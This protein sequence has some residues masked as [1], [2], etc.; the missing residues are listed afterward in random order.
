MRILVSA[1]PYDKGK[2]GISVYVREVV[3]ELVAQ[4]HE[5][6]LLIEPEARGDW[7]PRSG[8]KRVGRGEPA[9]GRSP[10]RHTKN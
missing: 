5:L 6:T 8:R 3:R 1:I 2:S 10:C 9:C 4:G 7:S